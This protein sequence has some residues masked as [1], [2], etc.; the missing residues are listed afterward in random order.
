MDDS[1]NQQHTHTTMFSICEITTTTLSVLLPT[2]AQ[3]APELFMQM[4][5][6]LD[7]VVAE[8]HQ[9]QE[10]QQQEQKRIDRMMATAPMTA[11]AA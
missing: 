2:I 9:Q 5:Y 1:F 4:I 11:P 10:L 3:S 8:E 7:R 6:A